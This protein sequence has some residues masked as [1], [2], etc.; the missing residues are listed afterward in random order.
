MEN[1]SFPQGGVDT[2]NDS[3]AKL[4]LF[5]FNHVIKYEINHKLTYTICMK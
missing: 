5:S 2:P 4:I 3:V 1:D